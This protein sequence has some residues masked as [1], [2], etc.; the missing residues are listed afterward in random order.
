M[1]VELATPVRPTGFSPLQYAICL[2]GIVW[3]EGLRF[4]HQRER[5][6]ASLVRPLVW[7]FIFATGFRQVLGVSIIP[8]YETYVLYEVYITPGLMLLIQLFNGMQSSLSM[9]YDREMG[10]MRTLLV[11]PLPRWYLLSSKLVAGMVV[12]LPQVY[13]FLAIAWFWEIEPPAIGY[14]AVLPALVLSGLMLGALGMLMSSVSKQLENFAGAMNF[15]IFPMFFASS[16]LYPL[17]RVREGSRAALL[18]MPIQPFHPCG[19]TGAI[20]ALR[21]GQLGFARGGEWMHDRVH[22]R[23]DPCLRSI[24]RIACAARRAWRRRMKG[25]LVVMAVVLASRGLALAADPRYPDWPCNQIK[26]PELSVAAVWAGPPVDDVANVGEQDP[27]IR[28]LVVRLAARRTPLED[29]QRM[30]SDAITGD[31][32]ERQH[33]AKLIFAGL[34][35]AL[36]HERSEVMNGIERF[37]RKQREFADQVRSTILQLRELQDMPGRDQSKVDE[38]VGRVE[39]DT[40]IFDERSKTIGYVCEVPVLIEQRLFALARAI[41]QALE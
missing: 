35:K 4:L 22:G 10:N 34:F 36:N 38:L 15:V 8:P 41:Q 23:R 30:I 2:K 39:W 37:S 24:A 20:C 11:S 19:R 33:K 40:R 31:A 27:A 1:S 3:R 28:D 17:W 5:F 13:T 29:A 21:R 14:I 16:A 25:W 12:S 9:V 7:L 26:V 18:H 32:A 6:V